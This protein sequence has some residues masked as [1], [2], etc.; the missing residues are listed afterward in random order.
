MNCKWVCGLLLLPILALVACS[1]PTDASSL[2]ADTHPEI[3]ASE[4]IT[5]FDSSNTLS[6]NNTN[7]VLATRTPFQPLP[8]TNSPEAGTELEETVI[9]DAEPE[10]GTQ[11]LDLSVIATSQPKDIKARSG[12]P[13]PY[14]D[15][16]AQVPGQ[17][18]NF[19]LIGSDTRGRGV[20]RT[21]TLIIAS[22]RPHDRSVSLI[23]IPRDL[24][25]YIPQKGMH[26]I[27]TAYLWGEVN[28]YPGG[29]F[30]LLKDT[31]QYNLGVRIDKYAMVNFNSF[32]RAVD[33]LGGI[34]VPLACPYTDWHL[35][36]PNRSDQD[37]NNWKLF[38]VGPG[39]VKM[40]GDLALWY[41]RSR[42][43][44]S[45]YDRGRRQQ[46]VLRA[47][48]SQAL[49]INV[50]S[51]IPDLYQQFQKGVKTDFQLGDLLALAPLLLDIGES[52]IRSYYITAG[53]VKSGFADGMFVLFPKHNRIQEL[54]PRALAPSDG[55]DQ[56]R[57][58]AVVE[59]CNATGKAGWDQLAIERL[60]YAGFGTTSCTLEDV[61]A[62]E[63]TF[64]QDLR[65]DHDP[66]V[67]A[68]LLALFGLSTS[69]IEELFETGSTSHFRI[70]LG[71]DFNPCF[72]PLKLT[73]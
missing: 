37:P 49:R 26:K 22:V 72:N 29:G 36:N 23:S 30:A 4:S 10:N 58:Q 14:P 57:I 25:V 5:I 45:D 12:F 41:A 32:I 19:L 73:H 51:N 66:S 15:F 69:H 11:E 35:V 52:Q 34:Q 71:R 33:T 53:M 65:T 24:Y 67:S 17:A 63:H 31:I 20:A 62:P 42:M 38:T 70:L 2:D 28:H 9:E 8:L 1:R 61:S 16:S 50:I 6:P 68:S 44:S 7:E 59:V 46:E 39:V 64:I 60:H 55:I 3:T 40:D 56:A 27:N 43:K 13:A 54:I 47:I 48:Y 21:D 18:I